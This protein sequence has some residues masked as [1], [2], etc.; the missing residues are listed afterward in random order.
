[1]LGLKQEKDNHN[2][3]IINHM[4]Y[5]S[6][7]KLH[8]NSI[9]KITQTGYS[10]NGTECILIHFRI[11]LRQWS[12]GD[13]ALCSPNIF[14]YVICYTVVTAN[15]TNKQLWTTGVGP[16]ILGLAAQQTTFRC[17]ML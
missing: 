10:W 16:P 9:V 17:T 2:F 13:V 1:M 12:P 6:M 4:N 11:F 5:E 3:P 8:D 14:E 15:I 7:R